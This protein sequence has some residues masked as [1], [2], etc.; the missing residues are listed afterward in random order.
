MVKYSG[1]Q[2]KKRTITVNGSRQYF[3]FE[4]VAAEKYRSKRLFP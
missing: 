3:N 4:D 1:S 2:G